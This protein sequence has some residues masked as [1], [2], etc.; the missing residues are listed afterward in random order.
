MKM[1]RKNS[2]HR[3]SKG[4]V[5]LGILVLLM[6]VLNLIAWNNKSFC[7]LYVAYIFPIWVNTY[8]RL[9]GQLP[10]SVGEVMLAAAVILI[11]AGLLFGALTGL[12]YAADHKNKKSFW[13]FCRKYYKG[14]LW[15]SAC[16]GLVMT[17][18]CFILYHCS[19]FE[20]KYEIGNGE[21]KISELAAVRDHV[22]RQANALAKEMERD[23]KGNIVYDADMAVLAGAA[24]QQL[25]IS[26]YQ[27]LSGYYP[28]PKSIRAS[29]FLSQ[30]YMQGYYFPFSMEAN[31]NDVMYIT[32]IP[33]TMCHELA[34]VKGFIYEDEANFISYLACIHSEDKL[35]QYSGY[36]SVLNYLDKAYRE[37]VKDDCSLCALHEKIST[38]VKRD[39]IFLTQES[40]EQVEKK[41]VVSTAAVKK[42]SHA[43]VDANQRANG[44][45]DGI[46]SY[47]R[48]TGLLLD[49]Y[50]GILYRVTVEE[51]EQQPAAGTSKT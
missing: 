4:S 42:A 8:G 43:F 16:I 2:S 36:L 39:N 25:G 38:Q 10:F 50:D 3:I 5:A 47:D 44:I 13:F 14:M 28:P 49:Y 46:A 20:E 48:V 26:G 22:V 34:H 11:A 21:Y 51:T 6:L 40:W 19:T 41:A 29:E 23:E 15:L 17:C 31:Y 45:E 1:L 37:A 27:Q 35:F 9:T 12:L 18:N 7:D 24:M 30:Q 32:N 33:S